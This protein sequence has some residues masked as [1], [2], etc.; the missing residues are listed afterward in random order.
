MAEDVSRGPSEF[1]P[2]YDIVEKILDEGECGGW[3][4]LLFSEEKVVRLN[5]LVIFTKQLYN[6]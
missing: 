5:S 2:H 6:I 1:N 4:H 3:K